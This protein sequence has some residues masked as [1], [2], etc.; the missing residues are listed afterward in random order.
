MH[1]SAQRH[2]RRRLGLV[3]RGIGRR[4]GRARKR[5]QNH[6]GIQQLIAIP[7]LHDLRGP[8]PALGLILILGIAMRESLRQ[9]LARFEHR[10]D[11]AKRV[12]AAE[13]IQPFE[14]RRLVVVA[15]HP[16]LEG[17]LGQR[18][19]AIEIQMGNQRAGQR[20]IA[21]EVPAHV[22]RHPQA[23]HG[24]RAIASP[25]EPHDLAL[26]QPQPVVHPR[27]IGRCDEQ[28]IIRRHRG[29]I[30]AIDG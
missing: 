30:A 3:G 23:K 24:V 10:H 16:A 21:V 1:W 26:R 6:R 17:P 11:V 22:Q 12:L 18:D 9:R 5:V 15:E 2:L 29:K 13:A 27:G 25:Q 14:Q 4:S 19:R 28:F 20:R 7:G 8:I